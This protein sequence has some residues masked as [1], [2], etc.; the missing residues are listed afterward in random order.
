MSELL[1]LTVDLSE[2]QRQVPGKFH[3]TLVVGL[4]GSG[5]G[6]VKRAKKLL[7]TR[8]RGV[9][10]TQYLCID[11]DARTF[12]PEA[13]LPELD[14]AETCEISVN[15]GEGARIL[16]EMARGLRPELAAWLPRGLP[17]DHL[18]GAGAGT[19]RPAGRFC[20][21]AHFERV[22]KVLLGAQQQI[23][24][25]RS[26]VD[27]MLSA[28][29]VDV[30]LS[31]QVVIYLVS[32]VCGGT[33]AG[34]FLDVALLLHHVFRHPQP[35]LK[36]I[37]VMPSAFANELRHR[38]T[39]M[40]QLQANA[41]AALTELEF[42]LDP[43]YVRDS[44][45]VFE[46]PAPV[47]R[48]R[49]G[50][51]LLDSC[52]L[53]EGENV[54]GKLVSSR[55]D[56][57][58]L[59]ARSL[60]QDLAS[61]VGASDESAQTDIHAWQQLSECRESGRPKIFSSLAVS[62]LVFPAD[63]LL[64]YCCLR[65]ARQALDH[66]E[67]SAPV[68]LEPKAVDFLTSKKLN[69]LG[70]ENNQVVEGLLFHPEGGGP[71]S[72]DDYKLGLRAEETPRDLA[73]KEE[74]LRSEMVAEGLPRVRQLV[75]ANLQRL[76]DEARKNL[77]ELMR[78]QIL[79]GGIGRARS[80]GEILLRKFQAM[81]REMHKESEDYQGEGLEDKC[82]KTASQVPSAW[83]VWQHQDF[84]ARLRRHH[85]EWV[86]EE[87]KEVARQSA[88]TLFDSLIQTL[89]ASLQSL[90]TAQSSLGAI[91]TLVSQNLADLEARS[92]PGARGYS[93]EIE[94]MGLTEFDRFYGDCHPDVPRTLRR[95][96]D[97][98]TPGGDGDLAAALAG[99]P[100]SLAQRLLAA[101]RP[102]FE[103]H[104]LKI[105]V[106]DWLAGRD[107]DKLLNRELDIL[108]NHCE[109][110]WQMEPRPQDPFQET[111]LVGIPAG[112]GGQDD[113]QSRKIMERVEGWKKAILK[114]HIQEPQVVLTGYP[115]ALEM[116]RRVHGARAF[117]HREWD[118]F[119]EKYERRACE[120]L[121]EENG[122][123]VRSPLLHLHRDFHGE[124]PPP[125]PPTPSAVAF[126]VALALGYVA[127]RGREFY[128]GVRD[129][130]GFPL[131][132]YRSDEPTRCPLPL[133]DTEPPLDRKDLLEESGSLFE[134]RREFETRI[135]LVEE[136]R[137]V[138]EQWA[139]SRGVEY[140]QALQSYLDEVL[141]PRLRTLTP[142]H[143]LRRYLRF[144]EACLLREI[145]DL[146]GG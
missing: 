70:P 111:V 37:F 18:T 130:G 25:L 105:N 66:L 45:W 31:P 26:Q 118:Q 17:V 97:S 136:M 120:S 62:S 29:Q 38:P 129:G 102:E 142:D 123:L 84:K 48:V 63:R 58:E 23:E 41:Y 14:P 114:A 57:F 98:L 19:M 69:E 112:S 86:E 87:V 122:V 116:T 61:S 34:I 2:G 88:V 33:G 106:V 119:R 141:R 21:F 76:Q 128:F 80:L 12:G 49:P 77:G 75:A 78:S 83:A 44:P 52:Y 100:G 93:L 115:F 133:D 72:P 79:E 74:R 135:P 36:G 5:A 92:R 90:E 27:E 16:D 51:R 101:A 42:F 43:H 39:H 121:R 3:P 113:E 82:R 124:L 107:Q 6:V 9:R 127:R 13:G 94:A 22:H 145:R 73:R 99:P 54:A 56:V 8:T 139:R 134:A 46:Y 137:Q 110:F 28:A 35:L 109:P 20:L 138:Q 4:G 53:V 1:S 67:A 125:E 89:A 143:P 64:T 71:W 126:S 144:Q 24:N 40:E 131:P 140:R 108:F 32:S 132:R 95:F 60:V 85:N 117:Y 47:G 59:I 11:S 55:I 10:A 7:A 103:P 146:A 68:D 96:T 81:L 15:V 30:E 65:L 50:R 91:K 104:L